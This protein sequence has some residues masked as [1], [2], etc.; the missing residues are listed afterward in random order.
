MNPFPDSFSEEDAKKYVEA[1]N[2]IVA[3]ATFGDSAPK[4]EVAIE[5]RN[6]F[7]FLQSLLPK[8][9]SNIVG[10]VKV[11]EPEKKTRTR[12]KGSK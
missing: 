6:H 7:A 8:I 10:E 4:V 12:S 9:K 11:H 2:Y 5:I 3:N 1:L